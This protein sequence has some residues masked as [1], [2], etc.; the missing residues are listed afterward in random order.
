MILIGCVCAGTKVYTADGTE[1]PIENL[2]QHDGILGYDS[3]TDSISIE[4]IIYM[5]KPCLKPCVRIKTKNR[6]LECSI[7]HPILT[8]ITH[9]KRIVD[10]KVGNNRTF[11]YEYSF[12]EAGKLTGKNNQG[13]VVCEAPRLNFG[14]INLEDPYLI[15]LLIGD[16]S[17]GFDKTPVLSNCDEDVLKYV[18]NK[19][20]CVTEKAIVTQILIQFCLN[21][22]TMKTADLEY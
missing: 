13:I 20:N 19:Y 10:Y 12:I 11:N 6:I 5:T 21:L 7:D 8:R 22:I 3:N 2:Y 4:P 9:S 14:N 15:G 18:E 1:V 16:G 17:Y